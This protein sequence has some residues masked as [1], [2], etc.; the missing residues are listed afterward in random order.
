VAL[1]GEAIAVAEGLSPRPLEAIGQLRSTL[2]KSLLATGR[3]E[4][5]AGEAE[6]AHETLSQALGAESRQANLALE[7][8]VRALLAM[9]DAAR[10]AELARVLVERTAVDHPQRAAREEL[11]RQALGAEGSPEDVAGD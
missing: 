2:S 3:A 5:A 1:A 9:G 6:L 8:R 10:A 7:H 11:L 4:E